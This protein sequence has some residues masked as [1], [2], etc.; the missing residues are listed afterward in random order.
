MRRWIL[1]ICFLSVAVGF[2][3]NVFA[4]GNKKTHPALTEKAV[5]ASVLDDYLKTEL[6]IDEGINAEFQYN[7]EMYNAYIKRRMEKG[8]VEN[9]DNPS[10]T[11]LKWIKA[12]SAI[13]DEDDSLLWSIRARHHFHD[14]IHNAGL[15]NKTDHP[16]YSDLFAWATGIYTDEFDVTGQ[17]ALVW[18]IEGIA[19]QKPTGSANCWTFARD[20]FYQALTS[21]NKSWREEYLAMTFLDLGCI[22]HMIEDTGVPAHTRNDFL[23]GHYQPPLG[24]G[25][26]LE[27]WVEDQV[28]ANDGQ[29]PW[30]G[31]G[32]VVFDKLAKYFDADTYAGSYL[33]D[34]Q[35]PPENLWGLAECTNYQFLSLS[36][37]F[38]CS[39]VK[40][41]FPHPAKEHTSELIEGRKVY[42]DG[43]NYGVVHLARDSYTYYAA[44]SFGY[45]SPV[46]DNTNTTDDEKVFIDYADITI[47]R[48]IDYATGLANYFFRGRLNGEPNW[49]DPNIV[50][51]TI[52]NDSNNSGVPQTLKAGTFEIYWDNA[53]DTRTQINPAYITF[54]PE[55]TPASTLPNDGGLTELIAQFAPP[56]ENVKQYV[57]VYRGNICVNPADPDPD[58][59]NA[60]AVCITP[61]GIFYGADCL[62]CFDP[63][64]TPKY[65]YVLFSNTQECVPHRPP[66]C[67]TPPNDHVFELTQHYAEPCCFVYQGADW[68]VEFYFSFIPVPLSRLFLRDSLGSDY[69]YGDA[70][71][72]I[73]AGHV[74]ANDITCEWPT[75]CSH[76][77]TATVTWGLEALRAFAERWLS[78][79]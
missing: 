42:F 23:Y 53:N 24:F 28:K 21:P 20:A 59:P 57:V 45:A 41:Q 9:P 8:K 25:N 15:D 61:P 13:E 62:H 75:A 63:G 51:L 52:T 10:R 11:I 31:T 30:S 47:P 67:K 70:P 46:I 40:Y 72:C 32:P 49:L 73:A 74:F 65:L 44:M 3:K 16:N 33:G 43:S 78:T 29:S 37:V 1:I 60:I 69:F 58:D 79:P 50:E 76:G 2:R 5:A 56:A 7:V 71:G 18:A 35:V 39:G 55:W 4:F 26:P 12:G 17:S 14:P 6:D 19:E 66:V 64:K 68:S 48:T 77:G 27:D 22:L 54:I 38:G 34:G 36:T